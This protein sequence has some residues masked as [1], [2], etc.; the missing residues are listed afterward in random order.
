MIDRNYDKV[1]I[2]CYPPGAGGNFLINCLS[3]SDQ[4]VLRNSQLAEQ[5]LK[6]GFDSLQKTNYF[7]DQL[8]QTRINNRW[9]DLGLGCVNLF[10]IENLDYLLNY[11]EII[12]KKFNYVVAKLIE[13]NK[14]LFIV[15]HSTQY[16][17]AYRKFWPR[18]RAVFLTDYHDFVHRRG[19]KQ[20]VKMQTL[21]NYW[22]NVRGLDWPQ[23][24][25]ISS[26]EF[27]QLPQTVQEELTQVFHSE[28]FRWIETE[29]TVKQLY[30]LAVKEYSVQMAGNTYKWNVQKNFT[31]NET[32]FITELAECSKW[33]NI[34][35]DA[36]SELILDYYRSWL[37]VIDMVKNNR[38]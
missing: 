14:Y 21:K 13:N 11:P 15:A 3:L 18:A 29:P 1:V 32:D 30:D 38:D 20:T 12:Q 37:T 33:L 24:P 26:D 31:G 10:G 28:I 35:L 16:L 8:D 27:L 4:C 2:V 9:N 5:Q 19:Y 17:D 6:V 36:P 23:D 25:P 22:D 7:S 34:T